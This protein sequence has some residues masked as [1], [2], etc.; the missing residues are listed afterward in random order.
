MTKVMQ[1]LFLKR[2]E[3][4]CIYR[5]VIIF[6]KNEPEMIYL[7]Q[8]ILHHIKHSWNDPLNVAFRAN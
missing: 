2:N 3:T 1:L 4:L 8:K 6:L 5:S 7:F